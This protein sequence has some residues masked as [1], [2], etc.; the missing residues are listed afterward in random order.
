MKNILIIGPARSGKTTL[1]K[2]IVNK[3]PSYNVINTDVLRDG[4]YEVFL[5]QSIR[6]KEKILLKRLFLKLHLK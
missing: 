5:N 6:R 1:A 2:M 3:F 4:I